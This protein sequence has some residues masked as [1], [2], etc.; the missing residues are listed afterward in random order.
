MIASSSAVHSLRPRVLR[1]AADAE[2]AVLTFFLTPGAGT[3]WSDDALGDDAPPEEAASAEAM[4][5]AD[6]LRPQSEK[7]APRP[8]RPEEGAA[9]SC[10]LAFLPP[11]LP[12]GPFARSEGEG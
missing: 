11:F 10:A 2:L 3:L 4:S 6:P 1:A 5:P 8:A 12:L 7:L 9:A